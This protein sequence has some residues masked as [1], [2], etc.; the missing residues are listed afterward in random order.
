[1]NDWM[2]RIAIVIPGGGAEVRRD[3]F[4]IL[5]KHDAG[6]WQGEQTFEQLLN[7]N[8][9]NNINEQHNK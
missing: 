7:N 1:M 6:H 8:N 9:D 4:Y 3:F 5:L 2:L